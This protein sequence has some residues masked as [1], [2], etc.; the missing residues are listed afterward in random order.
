M[1]TSVLK[2]SVLEALAATPSAAATHPIPGSV[3]DALLDN[4]QTRILCE[5]VYAGEAGT[6][7]VPLLATLL[8]HTKH[9]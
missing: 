6:T 5:Q 3:R 1:W 4:E 2:L 8:L 9:S 7:V